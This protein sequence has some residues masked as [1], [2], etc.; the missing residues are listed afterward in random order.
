ME[1]S[2]NCQRVL[3][4]WPLRTGLITWLDRV[5]C[6]QLRRLS[7][8]L[9]IEKSLAR[10]SGDHL[11]L[12]RVEFDQLTYR[13]MLRRT[14]GSMKR[15]ATNNATRSRKMGRDCKARWSADG[16]IARRLL[17]ILASA[18]PAQACS[19]SRTRLNALATNNAT[20]SRKMGRDCK[21]RWSADGNIARRLVKILAS[22]T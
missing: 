18:S 9:L 22:A 21:A 20:R 6:D 3:I 1:N 10:C 19:G 2:G 16:N 4:A 8:V 13:D 14:C 5:E 15:L 17:K 11:A 12:D 7:A